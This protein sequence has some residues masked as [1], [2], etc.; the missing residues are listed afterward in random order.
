MLEND[1]FYTLVRNGKY[2]HLDWNGKNYA[3]IGRNNGVMKQAGKLFG[4]QKRLSVA[5]IGSLN[6]E[7]FDTFIVSSM[8]AGCTA[9]MI[10]ESATADGKWNYRERPLPT[11]KNSKP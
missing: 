10:I 2:Q 7:T 4:G 5:R 9:L 8:M 3:L 6:N 1:E 11:G